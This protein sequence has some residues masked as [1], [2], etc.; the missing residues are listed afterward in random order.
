MTM[1]VAESARE[2]KGWANIA[3]GA[4]QLRSITI[5]AASS[6]AAAAERAA[7]AEQAV[8]AA[9]GGQAAG[10]EREGD[11]WERLNA[12]LRRYCLSLTGS[13]WD[14]ED[15]AQD[16][17]LKAKR[18]WNGAGHANPEALLLRIAKH[19]WIDQAR[20][21]TVLSRILRRER[22]EAE[23][24]S[25]DSAL[26]ELEALFQ[27][28]KRHM[29]ALQR[30]VFILREVL[31]YSIAETAARLDTTEGAVKAALH[32][33]RGSLSRVRADLEEGAAPPATAD[34]GA[35]ALL[36]AFAA[37]YRLGDI[38][39]LVALAQQ[40]EA[41]PAAVLGLV[42]DRLA[43]KTVSARRSGNPPTARMAA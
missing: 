43:R 24:A 12:A 32:R 13:A 7:G 22:A 10:R 36:Q 42:R 40:G 1:T 17:W 8:A 11:G 29:S 2:Q 28:L 4:A 26:F 38:A 19:T 14:A 21:K 34:D 20:R 3:A 18:I 25:A 6:E 16:T 41:E 30:T 5:A 9:E 27:S 35:N 33:A 31:G 39:A 37:A 23:T 15:L